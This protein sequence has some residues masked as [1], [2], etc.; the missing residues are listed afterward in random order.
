[1]TI[2][3][4]AAFDSAQASSLVASLR[5]ELPAELRGTGL[6]ALTGGATAEVSDLSNEINAKPGWRSRSSS[7]W[8]SCFSPPPTAARW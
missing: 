2:T 3:P 8:R 5:Q 4:R 6:Q 1:M 7:P